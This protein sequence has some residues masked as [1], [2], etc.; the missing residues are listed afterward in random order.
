MKHTTFTITKSHSDKLVAR[1][2]EHFSKKEGE[3]ILTHKNGIKE[4]LIVGLVGTSVMV[5]N[6]EPDLI[7]AFE[8]EGSPAAKDMNIKA[9]AHW[10]YARSFEDEITR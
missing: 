3:L 1:L 2:N 9:A 8:I 6:T 10:L 5:Y 4:P 7:R